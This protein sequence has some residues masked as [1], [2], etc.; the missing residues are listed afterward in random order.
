MAKDDKQVIKDVRLFFKKELPCLEQMAHYFFV[1]TETPY[2]IELL[3][4]KHA[5]NAR[6]SLIN[7]LI[8]L[9]ALPDKNKQ[10]IKMKYFE[11]LST[12]DMQRKAGYS[13]S[14]IFQIMSEAF[15][16]F[17]DNF[18]ETYDFRA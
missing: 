16:M 17:A 13:E 12:K 1:G 11:R 15:L 7:V 14:R 6:A 4:N 3:G 5:D 8:A 10:M 2:D 9:Q 18:R